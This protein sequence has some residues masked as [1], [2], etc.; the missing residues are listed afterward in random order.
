[1]S[2]L[3][4]PYPGQDAGDAGK[5][6]REAV[7]HLEEDCPEAPRRRAPGCR[8]RSGDSDGK[9]E[10]VLRFTIGFMS[11]VSGIVAGALVVGSLGHCA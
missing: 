7:I 8:C 9:D 10:G 5:S 4:P 11:F 1:M 3:Y 6:P 2:F